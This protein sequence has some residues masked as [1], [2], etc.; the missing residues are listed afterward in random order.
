MG[1][2]AATALAC[3]VAALAASPGATAVAPGGVVRCAAAADGRVLGAQALLDAVVLPRSGELAR[4]ARAGAEGRFRLYRPARIAVRSG[5]RDVAV[6]VPLGWR[7]LVAVEWGG[8]APG[9]SAR[10]ETCSPPRGWSVY[11]G[12]FHLRD[13]A[14][15][16]PMVVRVGGVATT[17]RLGLGRRCG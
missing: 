5:A 8:A 10:F 12:G 7:H 11:E 15:C 3:T 6:T 2:T 9:P 1:R 4:P 16:A 13:A 14:V 17:V